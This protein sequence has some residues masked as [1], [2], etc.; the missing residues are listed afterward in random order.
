MK[1]FKDIHLTSKD[2]ASVFKKDWSMPKWLMYPIWYLVLFIY[3]VIIKFIFINSFN[4]IKH[5]GKNEKT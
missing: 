5:I 3:L 1:I 2:L 4:Y